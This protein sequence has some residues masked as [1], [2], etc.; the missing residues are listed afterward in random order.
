MD[1]KDYYQVLGVPRSAGPEE[2]RKAFRKLARQYHPDVAKNKAVAEEKFKQINE[3]YE[4]LGDPEK[5]KKY[6]D[7]GANWNRP[8]GFSPP[9]GWRQ[10]RPR[11][12]AGPAQDFDF[13]FGGTGF[14]S[15]F[16]Q[17]FG[18]RHQSYSDAF[19]AP[20]GE[21]GASFSSEAPAAARG[22]DIQGDLLVTMQEAM[23]GSIR[24]ISLQR[25]KSRA[26][27]VDTHSFR[28]RIPAGVQEGQLIR[29]A[30]KGEE[31]T[32]GAGD[33][34]LRVRLA[35]HPDFR[36][37]GADLEYTLELSPWEAVLGATLPVPTLDGS[38]TLKMPPGTAN[39]QKLRI[40]DKGL[41]KGSGKRGDL[42]V[43][44]SIQVPLE[45][46]GEEK[47]LWE[48]LAAKSRFNPR[49]S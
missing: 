12:G 44:V 4:V 8:G 36:T 25:R 24:Q 38:V 35:Q 28:V 26:G 16:E 20:D 11:R 7:L 37:R 33:L 45:V 22:A 29:V 15:F 17:F 27:S 30:G 49:K 10:A 19:S 32:G 42:Y 21:G 3:A 1:F 6:D 5:R 40:R 39:G 34:F 18:G 9:P 2:V 46:H 31:A 41:P 43:L 48:Q 13:E 14:S 23:H 47:K